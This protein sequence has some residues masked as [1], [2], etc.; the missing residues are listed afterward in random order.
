MST[1]A[2]LL[3]YFLAHGNPGGSVY[4]FETLEACG[5]RPEAPACALERVCS[6]PGPLC[7]PPRWSKARAAWVAV[8]SR[9]AAEARWRGI[10]EAADRVAV[11]LVDCKDVEG[12]VLEDCEPAA[13]W[14]RGRGQARKLAFAIATTAYW[15]SGLREDVQF[16]YPPAG[17]GPANEA[18]LIQ[19]MPD[20]APRFAGW[21]PKAERSRVRKPDELEA[22]AQTLLG[23]SPAALERCLEIGG[24]ALARARSSCRGKGLAWDTAMW[25]QYGTGKSCSDTSFAPKRSTTLRN[26]EAAAR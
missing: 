15:E 22:F 26:L 21:L 14:P 10:F 19:V 7:A 17:R 2:L 20:Q 24:R 3:A 13:G 11:R 4:S 5:T 9:T 12:S 1:A 16:G 23:D 8:E 18:C 25:S 6:L